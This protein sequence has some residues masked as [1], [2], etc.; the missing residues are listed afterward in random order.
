MRASF[1]VLTLVSLAACGGDLTV[2][3]GGSD[4][5]PDGGGLPLPDRVRVVDG[6]GQRARTGE[7]LSDPLVVQVVDSGAA[8]VVGTTV[9]FSFAG[10]PAGAVLEPSLATTDSSGLASAEVRMGSESGAQE[11][12]ARVTGTALT[13]SFTV[14]AT[15]GRGHGHDGDEGD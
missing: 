2:P 4:G 1:L 13:A 12:V 10:D 6:D 14:T 8:P 3:G 5:G 7:L 11:V 15:S 9:E